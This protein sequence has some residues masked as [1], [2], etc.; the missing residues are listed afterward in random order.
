MTTVR[1]LLGSSFTV[2]LFASSPA[3]AA[4]VRC[5]SRTCEESICSSPSVI[6]C[7][8]WNDG[9]YDGWAVSG[10][11][12]SAG[13]EKG[14]VVA[15]VGMGGSNGWEHKILAGEPG[16]IWFDKG[17]DLGTGPIHV[18]MYIKFSPGYEHEMNCGL[19]KM[20]YLNASRSDSLAH[21]IMAGVTKASD[22]EGTYSG[23]DHSIGVFG[24]DYYGHVVV[25]P[26]QPGDKPV[27]I[28]PD[29]WYSVELMAQYI[30][31]GKNTV[32]MWIDGQLQMERNDY[33]GWTDGTPFN[34]V[35]DTSW[36]GGANE[37]AQNSSTQYVY[38]DNHVV[39]RSYIGPIGESGGEPL[40]ASPPP[41]PQLL[42]D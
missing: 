14:D 40:P 39:S 9:S 34:Q 24:F 10:N 38:K 22:L 5:G 20:F 28:H 17:L 21:R 13:D 18:R 37:C 31:P 11:R 3:I 16:T 27:L 29:R 42:G 2:L 12:Y 41:A 4:D 26:D 1:W 25:L 30:A 7:S 35:Q 6:E 32:K 23:L 8:D 15:N 36:F 33:G 19:Q